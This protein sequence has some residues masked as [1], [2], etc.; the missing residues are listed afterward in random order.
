MAP[1][2]RGRYTSGVRGRGR[3]HTFLDEEAEVGKAVDGELVSYYPHAHIP[4]RP[5]V[6]VGGTMSFTG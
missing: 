1:R 3:Y 5:P 2:L 6:K 4:Q